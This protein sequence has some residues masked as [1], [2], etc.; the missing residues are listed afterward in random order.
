MS[1]RSTL[2][3]PT[4]DTDNSGPA[5]SLSPPAR[6][7]ATRKDRRITRKGKELQ[8]KHL[9]ENQTVV[10]WMPDG[11]GFLVSK[12]F[13]VRVLGMDR[14]L[15]VTVPV[16]WRGVGGVVVLGA[17]VLGYLGFGRGFS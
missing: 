7:P 1:L 5:L 10:R 12:A 9:R 14:M 16:S 4:D 6:K 8:R 11:N 13:N 15:T 17:V 2:S 3:I